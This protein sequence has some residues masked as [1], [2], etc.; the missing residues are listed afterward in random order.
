M[1]FR[2]T[3]PQGMQ[4]QA[5]QG[6]TSQQKNDPESQQHA[7]DADQI[8]K[9]TNT[10]AQTLSSQGTAQPLNK[11]KFQDV[12]TKLDAQPNA[13]LGASDTKQ[14]TQIGAAA[15]KALQ[16]PQTAGQLKQLIT[17][18]DQIDQQKQAKV[19]QQQQQVGTNQPAGQQPQQPGQQQQS[20]P[21][22]GQTK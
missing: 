9:S 5:P 4:S 12:M 2:S 3:P 7:L 18:A 22:A 14:L 19:K 21:S 13:D 8:K 10:L 6:A 15:S 16:S 11:V 17:K 1:L 20:Q